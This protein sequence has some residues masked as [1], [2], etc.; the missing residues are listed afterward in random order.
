M[1]GK[2]KVGVIVGLLSLSTA[3]TMIVSDQARSGVGYVSTCDRLDVGTWEFGEGADGCDANRFGNVQR[4]KH[5]YADFV[6]D[7]SKASDLEHRREYVTNVNALL[8]DL[9]REYMHMRRPDVADDEVEMFAEAI[10]AVAQQETYWSHYRKAVGDGRYKLATG[11]HVRSHGMMQINQRYH[12][13]AEQDRSFD[14]VGNVAFGIEHYYTEWEIARETKCVTRSSKKREQ[15]LLNIAR[16]AYSTYNGGP[17][18]ACRFLR[19]NDT[20]SIND[21]NFYKKLRD[22]D[23]NEFVRDYDYKLRVNLEC[24]RS[25]DER[26]AVAQDRMGEYLISRTLV[27][28]DGSSCV[29]L[30]GQT[31]QCARDA[32]VFMC[33]EGVSL[34]AMR[35]API[36]VKASDEDI[37]AMPKTF[38]EDRLELCRK[39]FPEMG[40][41]GDVVTTNLAIVVRAQIE[42][43]AVGFTKRGQSFQILDIESRDGARNERFYRVRLPNKIEGWIAGGNRVTAEKIATVKHAQ[44]VPEVSPTS[45]TNGAVSLPMKGGQVEISKADGLKLL[46]EPR[47]DANVDSTLAKGAVVDVLDV[48]ISGAANEIWLQVKTGEVMGYIYA[49]RTYPTSTIDQWVKVK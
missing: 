46:L 2:T 23:W 42:G 10:R 32:R 17:G 4:L 22:R 5:V 44:S 43:K 6:F 48:T 37:L 30:D 1:V 41:I 9:T 7:R 15:L 3:V 11:D 25:G 29:S 8:R 36:K 27:M 40:S 24:M 35:S 12:A 13:S 33:L 47:E 19:A 31:L 26:C 28:D 20:W 34:E 21:K 18:A 39:A 14:I 38:H 45:K 16:G 49:G